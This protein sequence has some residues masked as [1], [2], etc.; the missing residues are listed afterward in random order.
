LVFDPTLYLVT[1]PDLTEGRNIIDIVKT[2]VGGGVTMVQLREK[3][4]S[5][6]EFIEKAKA[7]RGFLRDR[8]VP[9]I[10]NDRVDVVQAVG[11]DGVH[12]G[13]TDIPYVKAREILGPDA[14]IGVSVGTLEETEK[15]SGIGV[16][17]FGVSPIFATGTKP[18]HAPPLGLE[19]L[20]K[21]RDRIPETLIGIG[22]I[23]VSNAAEVVAAGAD[24]VA[25]VT[26][27]TLAEDPEAAAKELIRQIK[28]NS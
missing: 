11:A 2:A 5:T 12:I 19:G 20:S 25:V 4:A 9:L 23:T 3:T 28:G 22:G 24:G 21:I 8:G 13:P 26:A 1:D 10:I 27:I 17:Y 16:D 15:M 7:I 6:R 14:V 18:D